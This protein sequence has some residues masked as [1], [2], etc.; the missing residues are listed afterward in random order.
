MQQQVW[1]GRKRSLEELDLTWQRRR[2]SGE[3][4]PRIFAGCLR[5]LKA[6]SFMSAWRR[7]AWASLF[8]LCCLHLYQKPPQLL[9]CLAKDESNRWTSRC[10][11]STVSH[12]WWD[13]EENLVQ[14]WLFSKIP[15][16]SARTPP[17]PQF[18]SLKQLD[19]VLKSMFLTVVSFWHIWC[20]FLCH[21]K[22]CDSLHDIK[23]KSNEFFL[24]SDRF[25]QF[26]SS[27]I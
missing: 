15:C 27:M 9:L 20:E 23:L 25:S 22:V 17:A 16:H 7:S 2:S 19:E 11:P 13:V 21:S 5:W 10:H 6:T 3:Q 1:S 4:K 26:T 12:P 8:S 18:C 24:S 14:S